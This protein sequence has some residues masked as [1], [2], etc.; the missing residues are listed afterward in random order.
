M[1]VLPFLEVKNSLTQLKT[2]E[3]LHNN[4]AG[5][6]L[7]N[8]KIDSFL[9]YAD[10]TLNPKDFENCYLVDYALNAADDNKNLILSLAS[11]P[12]YFGNQIDEIKLIIKDIPLTNF[13]LMGTN[14]DSVKISYNG[15]DY[16]RFKDLDFVEQLIN[17]KDCSL[18]IYGRANLNRFMGRTSLQV[19][20]DDYQFNEN[21]SKYDF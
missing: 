8:N 1:G 3:C 12:E 21:L 11:H 7:N 18:T 14:K 20:C 19:L 15:V 5:F 13:M 17:N 6:S 9:N 16:V 10:E 2:I 4:A